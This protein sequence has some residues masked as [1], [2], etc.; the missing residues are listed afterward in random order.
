M[1]KYWKSRGIPGP[2][3]S[4]IIGNIP[5]KQKDLEPF[6]L[7]KWTQEYGKIYGILDGS[8]KSLV[9]SD[10]EF[11]HEIFVKQFDN[12]YG[13]RVSTKIKTS[14]RNFMDFSCHP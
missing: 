2:E 4:L 13:R 14:K 3:P 9:T 11:L 12:F 1:K 10:P 8:R 7:Q 5:L 6:K